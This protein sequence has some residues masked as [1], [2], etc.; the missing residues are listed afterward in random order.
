[1]AK[2]T[3]HGADHHEQGDRPTREALR[4]RQNLQEVYRISNGQITF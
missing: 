1:M 4:D 2:R 3:E